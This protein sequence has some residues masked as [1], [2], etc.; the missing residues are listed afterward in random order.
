M[1]DP[2][3]ARIANLEAVVFAG[4][5]SPAGAQVVSSPGAETINVQNNLLV[6]ITASGSVALN[7]APPTSPQTN[8]V[9]VVISVNGFTNTINGGPFSGLGT[10]TETYSLL[11]D[12]AGLGNTCKLIAVGGAWQLTSGFGWAGVP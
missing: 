6:L 1:S 9:I 10:P 5:A 8:F 7:L 4:L 11:Q 3:A 2:I 12:S